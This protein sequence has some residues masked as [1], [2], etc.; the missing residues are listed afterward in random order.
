MRRRTLLAGVGSVLTIGTVTYARR[1]R[2]HPIHVRF[3]LTERAAAHGPAVSRRI[4]EYVE[5]SLDFPFW[6]VAVS[7]GG[8]VSVSTEHGYSVTMSGE[9]PLRLLE[10]AAGLGSVEP[11][12]H[13]NLLVTDGPTSGAPPGVGALHVAS[14]GGAERLARIDPAATQPMAVPATPPNRAMHVLIHEIGHALGLG[15]DHGVVTRRGYVTVASPMISLYAWQDYDVNRSRCG[16]IYPP[17]D[18]TDR[19]LSFEFSACARERL[20]RYRGGLH[21]LDG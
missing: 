4:Q 9:W 5:R 19:A 11:A 15:H 17:T 8:T 16:S 13:V 2:P 3:W 18:G 20:R 10:G 14:I 6:S 12:P 7:Y 1:E 21:P